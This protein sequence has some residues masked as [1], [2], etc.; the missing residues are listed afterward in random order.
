MRHARYIGSPTSC[1]PSCSIPRQMGMTAALNREARFRPSCTQASA[2]ARNL[3]MIRNHITIIDPLAMRCYFRC[4]SMVSRANKSHVGVEERF[5]A[6]GFGKSYAWIDLVNSKEYDG[7]GTSSDHLTD[8]GWIKSFR[9]HWGLRGLRITHTNIRHLRRMRDTLRQVVETLASGARLSARDLDNINQALRTPIHRCL[10][11]LRD[12]SYSLEVVPSSYGSQWVRAEIFRSLA[13]MLT[14]GERERL[15]ICP[16]PGCR[17]VFYDQTHGNTRRW[18]RDF[19]CGNRDK[20][21]RLRARR[22][23][24]NR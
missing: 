19:R 17:W 16:N 15:K 10:R 11:Q 8:M 12:L 4:T 6:N 3:T 21:R 18:C 1:F 5:L 13:L 20:V 9:N 14:T 24:I 7:Y 2:S 22:A 23:A